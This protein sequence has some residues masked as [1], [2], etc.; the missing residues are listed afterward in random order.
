MDWRFQQITDQIE[1][2]HARVRAGQ[3]FVDSAGRR[4]EWRTKRPAEEDVEKAKAEATI[5]AKLIRK[6]KQWDGG[7]S[8]CPC[9]VTFY[10]SAGALMCLKEHGVCDGCLPFYQGRVDGFR[11]VRAPTLEE[12]LSSPEPRPAEAS[13]MRA[14]L[15]RLRSLGS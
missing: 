5:R 10:G 11:W 7:A 14:E 8:Y 6:R 15:L 1:D 12:A 13:V 9:C 3:K 2:H 4:I